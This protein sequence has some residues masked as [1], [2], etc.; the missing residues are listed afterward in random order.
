[1]KNIILSLC[2]ILI[3]SCKAQT[4]ILPAYEHGAH[5]VN[6]AYY[7]DIDNQLDPYV[8]TWLYTNRTTSL[9]VTFQKKLHHYK[10]YRNYYEDLLIGEYQYIENGVQ[11]INT[12]PLLSNLTMNPWEHNITGLYFLTQYERPYCSDCEESIKRV[13][14]HLTDPQREY[15][16]HSCYIGF[17]AG[18]QIP[19]DMNELIFEISEESSVIPNGQPADRRIPKG[20]YLLIKQP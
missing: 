1:M 19:L 16:N 6:G 2:I 10:S 20:H 14:I 11:I 8:G 17:K 15:L 13:R 3:Y 12:L 9:K 4:P 18:Q 5:D 7:K